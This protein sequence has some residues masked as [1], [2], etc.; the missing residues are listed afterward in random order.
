MTHLDPVRLDAMMQLG[1]TEREARFLHLVATHSEHF[2]TRQFTKFIGAQPAN[3][4]RLVDFLQ[5]ALK[6]RHVRAYPYGTAAGRCYHLNGRAVYRALGKTDSSNRKHGSDMMVGVRLTALDFVLQK[7]RERYLEDERDKVA[8]F[9]EHGVPR[10]CLP[11]KVCVSWNS[12][13]PARTHFFI[14]KFPVFLP[15]DGEDGLVTLTYIDQGLIS[16]GSLDTHLKNYRPLLT[17][18]ET[19]SRVVFVATTPAYFE[20]ARKVFD[21]EFRREAH[22][23]TQLLEYFQRRLI[24][25]K[26]EFWRLPVRDLAA[27]GTARKRYAS[28]Q[29]EA[30]YQQWLQSG[31]TDAERALKPGPDPAPSRVQFETFL[32]DWEQL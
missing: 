2:L 18:L 1:Y 9:T 6:K 16:V 29:H 30:L 7:P 28:P 19:P 32:I 25:E 3:R 11:A 13:P 21:A 8:Y 15:A 24:W 5:K 20:E 17:S 14:D 12:S 22:A 31:K 26:K 27:L 23:D 10:D 4:G